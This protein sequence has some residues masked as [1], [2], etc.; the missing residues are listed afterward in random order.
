MRPKSG[1]GGLSAQTDLAVYLRAMSADNSREHQ[2][3]KRNLLRALQ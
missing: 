2:Q 1:S 3:L